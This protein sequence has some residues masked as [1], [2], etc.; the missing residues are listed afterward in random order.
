LIK[1]ADRLPQSR[2]SIASGD[3][4]MP[5]MRRT[6]PSSAIGRAIWLAAALLCGLAPA[7]RAEVHIEGSPAAVRVT[8]DQDAI[9]DVLAAFAATFKVKYRTAVRLD[10]IAGAAYSG[11]IRQVISSLLDGYNYMV[12]DDQQTL[13]IVVFGRRG[14]AVIPPPAPQPIPAKGIASQWR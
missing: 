6:F 13:E 10:A 5:T 9:A 11:S 7:A 12:K 2:Q 4:A 3:Q 14:E 1:Q 8:T